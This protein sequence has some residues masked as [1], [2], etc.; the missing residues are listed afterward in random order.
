MLPGQ[1]SECYLCDQIAD[2]NNP[3]LAF[4]TASYPWAIHAFCQR[5][6]RDLF[7]CRFCP[8][9]FCLG[10]ICQ[11]TRHSVQV[12]HAPLLRRHLEEV[13]S[14]P[15]AP[16]FDDHDIPPFDDSL[17]YD[18]DP[19]C[20]APQP[21][22]P[23]PL[24][25]RMVPPSELHSL[26]RGDLSPEPYD[27]INYTTHSLTD[28]FDPVSRSQMNRGVFL[29]TEHKDPGKGLIDLAVGVFQAPCG[30]DVNE[31][32]LSWVL[33]AFLLSTIFLETGQY[34]QNSFCFAL[35]ILA[36]KLSPDYHPPVL[37]PDNARQAKFYYVSENSTQK[38]TSSLLDAY[39]PNR[40][41]SLESGH[42]YF[43]LVTTIQ[44]AHSL[45]NKLEPSFLL[46][47]TRSTVYQSS[48]IH[49]STPRCFEMLR[50][51]L[52][53]LPVQ[54][55]PPV[56]DATNIRE[57]KVDGNIERLHP[58]PIGIYN[59]IFWSDSFEAS[60]TKQNRGSV[61]VLFC[62]IA[63]PS[64]SGAHSMHN[65]F[66]SGKNTFLVAVGP[67]GRDVSH[68]CVWSRLLQ[69][70][71]I[72]NDIQRP[73]VTYSRFH[74]KEMHSVFPVFVF[75]QDTPERTDSNGLA[76]WKSNTNVIYGHT[77]PVVREQ[78]KL[79]SCPLCLHCRLTTHPT[80]GPPLR[81]CRQ[82]HDWTV[83]DLRCITYQ[84]LLD[85]VKEAEAKHLVG[86][87]PNRGSIQAYLRTAGISPTV[88]KA[89]ASQIYGSKDGHTCLS[90]PCLWQYHHF[91]DVND[92]IEVV[93]HIREPDHVKT[94]LE[95]KLT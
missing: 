9:E 31:M 84:S 68:E 61:W 11:L 94:G 74:G 49:S 43:S 30:S 63:T 52:S 12:D 27:F 33:L 54:N 41:E 19:Q 36:S 8:F 16:D 67:S 58:H 65:T 88:A 21:S 7:Y 23:T 14:V 10:D 47:L 38:G 13:S 62:S 4:M 78:A 80:D 93:M 64:Q 44:T 73:L 56:L 40:P 3:S 6:R 32:S 51:I 79:P 28:T 71:I 57:A 26:L 66:N 90:T 76:S 70:L 83:P 39:N 92:S 1:C 53:Q 81:R 75:L 25:I 17:N 5:C 24:E 2:V 89:L 85:S 91:V 86:G 82:C 37:L 55:L 20:P 46:N 50:V 45:G 69:D 34:L 42:A 60:S 22:A 77:G 72:V 35:Q 48:F 18:R 15:S 87:F 59:L 29:E 95:S